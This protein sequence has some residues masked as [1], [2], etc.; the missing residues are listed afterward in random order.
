MRIEKGDSLVRH[1]LEVRRLD[2]T[3]GTRRREIPNTKIIGED[4][5]HIRSFS[6]LNA[7][8]S[9]KEEKIEESFN[10]GNKGGNHLLKRREMKEQLPELSRLESEPV[11]THH[12][13]GDGSKDTGPYR[14]A[15]GVRFPFLH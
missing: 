14:D 9:E 4:K 7:E 15:C 6:R 13:D 10:H 5:N 2:F 12:P 3:V 8:K 1:P 11:V